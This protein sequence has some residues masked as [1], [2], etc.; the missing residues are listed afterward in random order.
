MALKR[1][2]RMKYAMYTEEGKAKYAKD[3]R[4]YKK[5]Q[6]DAA[7]KK[8]APKKPAA[9]KPAAKKPPTKRPGMTKAEKQEMLKGNSIQDKEKATKTRTRT[10]TKS[11]STTT[12]TSKSKTKTTPK[13]KPF[14]AKK[15]GPG[16]PKGSTNKTQQQ[17]PKNNQTL[18]IRDGAKEAVKT[19]KKAVKTVTK[20]A[21]EAKQAVGKKV[22]QVKKFVSKESPVK[23]PTTT[24]QKLVSK[25]NQGIKKTARG[26]GRNIKAAG[27]KIGRGIARDPRSLFKGAKGAGISYLAEGVTKAAINRAFKPKGMT[28]SEYAKKLEEMKGK[29]NIVRS[30][31]NIASKIRGKSGE[32][33]TTRNINKQKKDNNNK[34]K[35]NKSRGLKTQYSSNSARKKQ[36]FNAPTG[37]KKV[38]KRFPSFR[39]NP[40][41]NRKLQDERIKNKDTKETYS[42]KLSI[43][44]KKTKTT[45]TKS[46]SKKM[47]AIE[48]R[49]RERFGDAH[50]DRLKRQ[51]EA[52]KKRRKKK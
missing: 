5:A 4:A 22:N 49:N 50:V 20:K 40:E 16:R 12:S 42:R 38:D 8:P 36:N 18:K 39:E 28:A 43:K 6:A 7:K 44:A 10:K 3:M 9:K 48:K 21:G 52:F 15:R 51:H 19:T 31:K 1:P 26:V 17:A 37:T 29:R 34:L 24:G 46:S 11:K 2:D 47:H 27:L 41:A 23:K 30:V 14:D 33:S 25:A 32:S 35:V 13:R 45:P